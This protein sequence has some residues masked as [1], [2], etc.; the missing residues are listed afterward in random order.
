MSDTPFKQQRLAAWQPILTP[1]WV[2]GTFLI[3]GLIFLPVGI[4][5]KAQSDAVAEQVIMYDGKDS[6]S[7]DCKITAA[8]ENLACT[9]TFT[10]EKDMPAPVY[11]YYE[12]SNFY[13]NHRKYVKSLSF[14]QL[15]GEESSKSDLDNLCSP[16]T[17]VDVGGVEMQLSPCGLVANSFFNDVISINDA[18]STSTNDFSETGIAWSS[19]LESK[20]SQPKGFKTEPCDSCGSCPQCGQPGWCT[21]GKRL[22]SL[23]IIQTLPNAY[24]VDGA[25]VTSFDTNGVALTCSAYYYPDDATTHYLYESY[26]QI[27]SALVGV[28]DEHF[29]VWMRTAGLPTF[30]KLYGTISSNVKKGDV[31]AFDIMNNFN[32]ESFT[33]TKSLVIST[34]SWF[35]GKN[36]FL[37][38][39]YIVVGAVCIALAV[40]FGVKHAVSP[41]KL[42]DTKF[43][44]WKDA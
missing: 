20:F 30:R 27:V 35:G 9:V 44:V 43:L 2:I 10:A 25:F 23:P 40:V 32:V 17:A 6:L 31:I 19:D 4:V 15:R 34:V 26:P 24:T 38:D 13:Q 7:N 12:L 16:L 22:Y 33:G 37:G 18:I 39:S 5:L 29:I 14:T 11:V 42:G 3:I 36:P 8:N 28:K 41:R 1:T 21:G